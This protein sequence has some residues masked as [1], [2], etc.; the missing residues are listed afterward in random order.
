MLIRS[1]KNYRLSALIFTSSILLLCCFP[2]LTLSAVVTL[3]SM[4]IYKTH[5]WL[6]SWKPTV[7][8]RCNGEN[9][10]ELP[11]VKEV[12]VTYSFNGDESWQPL[13]E[14]TSKKCKRCGFYEKDS[15]KSDDVFDEWEFC[16]SNFLDS[17]GKYRRVKEHEF[18]ASFLCKHCVPL[19]TDSSRDSNSSPPKRKGK[20]VA[21]IVLICALVSAMLILGSVAAYKYWLRKK[22]EQEQARFLKLFE[23]GDD[24][25]DDLD[26]DTL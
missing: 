10:T 11:D 21:V 18:D 5:E 26:M 23:D 7:Y 8:F 16:P 9:E 13:T 24:V 4:E 15:F 3:D 20:H 6:K 2:D 14:L 19:A 12:N 25:E 1:E 22:R 17:D